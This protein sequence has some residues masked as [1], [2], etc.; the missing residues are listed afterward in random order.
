MLAV[1]MAELNG[2]GGVPIL[3]HHLH[4][5]PGVIALLKQYLD[6]LAGDGQQVPVSI[7]TQ[8]VLTS[9]HLISYFLLR[10]HAIFRHQLL[11]EFETDLL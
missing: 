1:A 3:R 9:I 10:H 5:L 6:N 4:L 11:D 2:L 7:T 8:Q